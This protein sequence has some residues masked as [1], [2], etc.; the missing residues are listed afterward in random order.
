MGIMITSTKNEYW[1]GGLFFLVLVTALTR[2][3]LALAAF[4]PASQPTGYIAQNEISNF[5]LKSG[6]ETLFR[7]EY[8]KEFYSGNLHAHSIDASGNF[9][10]V[11]GLWGGGAAEFID[12]QPYDTGRRIATMKDDGT[13]VAFRWNSLS[14]AQ[15]A[16]IGDVATGPSILNFLRGDRSNE[17]QNNVGTFRQRGSALGDIVH[18]RPYYVSDSTDPTIFVGANDGMVHAIDARQVAGGAERWAYIPSMLLSKMKNLS[19]NPYVRDYFVDGQI[20]VGTILSGTKRILVGGLGAGGKGLYA[21]NI[22]GNAGLVA[23]S[24]ADVAGKVLWEISPT[25]VNYVAPTTANA[26]VNLGYTYGTPTIAKVAGTDAI[27][28]GNGYNNSTGGNYAAYLYVI[29]ANTGQLI[30]AIKAGADG[31][32][33]SPNGLFTPTAIDTNNDGSVDIVYAGDLNGKMW[34]FNLA[35]STAT[36]LY[37]AGQAITVAPAVSVHPNGGYM[38][39]FAT[40]AMFTTADTSDSTVHYAYGI[41]DGA[42]G[43]TIKTQTLTERVFGASTRV[44]NVTTNA[45]DWTAD[46]GWKV[47]LPAGEKVVGEGSFVANKRFYFTSHNPTVSTL[48]TGTATTVKGENWLMELDYLSGGNLN[49]P[50]LDLNADLLLNDSDRILYT[51]TDRY[52]ATDTY[53]IYDVT[54]LPAGKNMGDFV[55]V[56]LVGTN[57]AAGRVGQPILHSAGIPVGKYLNIGVMSQPI[58]VQL[59]T[60]NDTLFNQSP[61]VTF[62]TIPSLTAGG[63]GVAGG[64]FDVDDYYNG[65]SSTSGGAK[66]TATI[67]VS[68]TGQTT[69]AATLG[70]ISVEGVTV[71]P[72]LTISDI[73]NGTDTSGNATKIKNKVTGGYSATVSGSTI[74]IT[75]PEV[76]TFYNGKAFV[77]DAGSSQAITSGTPAVS[78]IVIGAQPVGVNTRIENVTFN[79]TSILASTI[80]FVAGSSES[81]IASALS[82]VLTTPSGF[83]KTITTTNVVDDTITFTAQSS[84]GTAK[85]IVVTSTA[86]AAVLVATPATPA[87]RPT[88][89]I[90]FAGT[91]TRNGGTPEISDDISMSGSDPSVLLGSTKLST[92]PIQPGRDKTPA[93]VASEVVSAIGTSGSVKAYVGGNSIT[94]LCQAES[95]S[96]VCLVDTTTYTNGSAIQLGTR[97]D[98]GGITVA[99]V[100]TAGGTA[101]SAGSAIAPAYSAQPNTVSAA[102]GDPATGWTDFKPALTAITFSGGVDGT[103]TVTATTACTGASGRD[104]QTKN[105]VHEYDDKYDRTGI[106]FLDGSAGVHDL[107]RA[108]GSGSTAQFKVLVQNQYLSPAVQLHIGNPSYVWNV[109]QGYIEVKTYT[110]SATLS[111]A[112]LPTYTLST[113]GSLAFNMPTDAFDQRDWWAGYMGLPADV[114]VGLHP[115][116]AGCVMSSAGTNDGN[117]IQPVNPPATVTATGNGT[118]GYS[119][120][121]TPATATGVRLNGALGLQVISASTLDSE[122]ELAVAGKPQYGWRLKSTAY[123]SRLL[124]EYAIYWHSG[125]DQSTYGPHNPDKCYGE[126]GWTKLANTDMRVCGSS[127]TSTTQTCTALSTTNLGTD[128]KIENFGTGC[129][130]TFTS[131]GNVETRSTT[132]TDGKVQI[133]TKTRNNDGSVTIRTQYT[134]PTVPN[135]TDP[136]TASNTTVTIAADGGQTTSG[137]DERGLQPRTGRISWRELVRP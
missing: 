17:V 134:P 60:L 18:S 80:T 69:G 10:A 45:M 137:G 127:A 64:H 81:A 61:D 106:N 126:T 30:Q 5:S 83:T 29:N 77:I 99:T 43:T 53:T 37:D 38:V 121:T 8:E 21:L 67:T 73:T 16:L 48:I 9:S 107:Y 76:G 125:K 131:T 2:L 19:V 94:A 6:S 50:F 111:L 66:A 49:Q 71:F 59:V 13:G 74:T 88:G 34:K 129:T 56:G 55:D 93:Q 130:T 20:N 119:S 11:A 72:A 32:A 95:T 31:S 112:S 123:H 110:T 70:V 44:R 102:A 40:G 84:G 35:A 63:R 128:P 120:S 82:G 51:A 113:I 12:A 26:Y 103:T 115:T 24:E 91:K 3:V 96:T 39:N 98:F 4:T 117:M 86:A 97:S 42:T 14:T 100:A 68:T 92:D 135:A 89:L 136:T 114:R 27:I 46:K 58:L 65:T 101:G 23:S 104:C 122:I 132:C 7:P 15:Q 41:W 62:P 33:A 75:A 57:V 36:T 79:G 1:A 116:Q 108:L 52:I 105:H 85:T 109:E 133:V 22:T 87:E 124:A 28:I 47:A 90:R 54:P 25:T 118:P 78:K